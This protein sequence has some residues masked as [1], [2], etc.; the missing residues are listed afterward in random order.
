MDRKLTPKHSVKRIVFLSYLDAMMVH[1]GVKDLIINFKI[2]N[3]N[4][5]QLRVFYKNGE[6]DYIY[7]DEISPKYFIKDS[8]FR[9]LGQLIEYMGV[10]LDSDIREY[11][12]PLKDDYHRVCFLFLVEK[13]KRFPVL[14]YRNRME[15]YIVPRREQCILYRP[16][17]ITNMSQY[18]PEEADYQASAK[19]INQDADKMVDYLKRV[20]SALKFAGDAKTETW[21]GLFLMGLAMAGL[22]LISVDAH[23]T[24]E[25]YWVKAPEP[26]GKTSDWGLSYVVPSNAFNG[27]PK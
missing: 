3:R 14:S 6:Y 26:V 16:D 27:T 15:S 23:I 8:F 10:R 12:H 11:S 4:E 9:S 7:L 22:E 20:E 21:N 1:Y 17:E 2:K 24:P 13:D 25:I 5:T 19:Q 18:F